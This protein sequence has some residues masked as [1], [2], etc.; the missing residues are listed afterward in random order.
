[1][2]AN[3]QPDHTRGTNARTSTDPYFAALLD[4]ARHVP[5]FFGGEEVLDAAASLSDLQP[6][7]LAIREK[8]PVLSF[9][10]EAF[11]AALVGFFDEAQARRLACAPT[12]YYIA[13]AMT[14]EQKRLIARLI[15]LAPSHSL[16][17][18]DMRPAS[19]VAAEPQWTPLTESDQD[20]ERQWDRL[21]A[22][23]ASDPGL[24]GATRYDFMAMYRSGGRV[25][26]K[27]RMTRR[28]VSWPEA[29]AG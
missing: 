13:R 2:Q 6:D 17:V 25:Y 23:I 4:A 16:P 14:P 5:Q 22:E 24:K 7:Y 29:D 18:T 21:D 1:M 15:E 26:F 28:S 20:W 8:M 27:H 11:C 3:H 19:A 10:L 12:V 9:D